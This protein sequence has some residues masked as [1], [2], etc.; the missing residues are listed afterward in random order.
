MN[1]SVSQSPAALNSGTDLS[2]NRQTTASHVLLF[3]EPLRDAWLSAVVICMMMVTMLA[4]FRFPVK[5]IFANVEVNYNEG[6]NAYRADMIEKGI[7]LYGAP[8]QGFGTATAYL[9]LSFHLVHGRGP[10]I[11]FRW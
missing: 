10:P 3:G 6:W 11:P 5:R 1:S 9:P 2:Q 7:H 8:L 4:L